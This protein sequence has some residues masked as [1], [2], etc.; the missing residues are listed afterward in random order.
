MYS[1][2]FVKTDYTR[3]P[4]PTPHSIG[5]KKLPPDG[6]GQPRITG[7]VLKRPYDEIP[8]G[9]SYNKDGS[10]SGDFGPYTQYCGEGL[11]NSFDLDFTNNLPYSAGNVHPHT[12]LLLFSLALNL[13]PKTI[14]ETGTF[15]GYSTLYLAKVCEIWGEGKVYTIDTNTDPVH[16]DILNNKYV[17]VINDYSKHAIPK[18]IE[19]EKEVQFAFIDSWKRIAYQ[20]FKLIH[21]HMAKGGIFAFHDTQFLNTG[22]TLYEIIMKN[23]ADE[24]DTM[25]FTGRTHRNNSHKFFGNADDRGL[26]VIRKKDEGLFHDVNDYNSRFLGS[27]QIDG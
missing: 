15:F 27:R 8:I 2:E 21:P 9:L 17:E 6:E 7:G 22:R 26:F 19:K 12:G 16:E 25:L 14:I 13:R 1:K 5:D 3:G 18:I 11:P 10:K 24:Y 4:Y 23:H 20:E